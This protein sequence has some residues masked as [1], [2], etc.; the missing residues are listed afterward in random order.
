MDDKMDDSWGANNSRANVS[1]MDISPALTPN[2]AI[3]PDNNFELPE[4]ALCKVL[5]LTSVNKPSRTLESHPKYEPTNSG[6]FQN[7][8][9]STPRADTDRST[10][11]YS[12]MSSPFCEHPQQIKHRKTVP[13]YEPETTKITEIA[14]K[15][16]MTV[17]PKRTS[18][19]RSFI[20]CIPFLF[21]FVFIGQHVMQQEKSI[22]QSLIWKNTTDYIRRV[23]VGQDV[24]LNKLI[25]IIHRHSQHDNSFTHVLIQGPTGTGKSYLANTFTKFLPTTI[26]SVNDLLLLTP[27]KKQNSNLKS[28]YLLSYLLSN[29]PSTSAHIVLIIDDL[30]LFTTSEQCLNL[31]KAIRLLT[32]HYDDNENEE[33]TSLF[34]MFIMTKTAISADGREKVFVFKFFY[35]RHGQQAIDEKNEQCHYYLKQELSTLETIE[36]ELLKRE[37]IQKCIE[38]QSY[39]Q[40]LHLNDHQIN[41]ILN[42]LPYITKDNIFYSQTG[43]KQI[44]AYLLMQSNRTMKQ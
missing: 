43:C 9:A 33:E 14:E 21:I 10:V 31:A 16:M 3:F 30:D 6:Q 27:S 28:D 11:D 4:A 12:L 17:R 29:L 42:S 44:P 5:D 34:I 2:T 8:I 26:I 18:L 23:V 25:T 37:H 39:I 32:K 35:S 22:D 7:Y 19:F 24:S 1:E 36:F 38:T 20:F 15:P 13:E 41:S 40:N